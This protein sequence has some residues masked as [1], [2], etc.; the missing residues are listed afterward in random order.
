VPI[1]DIERARRLKQEPTASLEIPSGYVQAAL[2][3]W[4]FTGS[5]FAFRLLQLPRAEA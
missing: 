4:A 5:Q 3:L 1:G 2:S